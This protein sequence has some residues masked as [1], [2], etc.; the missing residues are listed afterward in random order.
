MGRLYTDAL[1]RKGQ[2]PGPPALDKTKQPAWLTSPSDAAPPVAPWATGQE[3][4]ESDIA[5]RSLLNIM[6]KEEGLSS[7]AKEALQ[8]LTIKKEQDDTRQMHSAVAKLGNA[9]R[10]L[11]ATIGTR[12][13]LHGSWAKF[14]QASVAQWQEY[15][16]TFAKQDAESLAQIQEAQKALA[17]AK[18]CF[19]ESR[20]SLGVPHAI[21]LDEE[22]EDAAKTDQGSRITTEMEGVSETLN[23]LKSKADEIVAEDQQEAKRLKAG[24][25]NAEG[26]QTED[27][28]QVLASGAKIDRPHGRLKSAL[29]HRT[30]RG[31]VGFQP[32]LHLALWDEDCRD[33]ANF[34]IHERVLM[35]WSD[36][37][38]GWKQHQDV[39]FPDF[40]EHTQPNQT[41]VHIQCFGLN[42]KTSIAQQQLHIKQASLQEPLSYGAV[43]IREEATTHDLCVRPLWQEPPSDGAVLIRPRDIAS[44]HFVQHAGSVMRDHDVVSFMQRNN[45]RSSGSRSRTVHPYLE[46]TTSSHRND[47]R[48][49][50]QQDLPDLPA[51]VQQLQ[52]MW[53][54]ATGRQQCATTAPRHF[55]VWFLDTWYRRICPHPAS[56]VL[57]RPPQFWEEALLTP[58]IDEVDTSTHYQ[59]HLASATI[60]QEII[61]DVFAHSIFV[62]HPTP[63]RVAV[64]VVALHRVEGVDSVAM[65]A[66][67]IAPD[68]TVAELCSEVNRIA[69]EQQWAACPI[70]EINRNAVLLTRDPTVDAQVHLTNA[71]VIEFYLFHDAAPNS[72][73]NPS[74][75]I[76]TARHTW[77]LSNVRSRPSHRRNLDVARALHIDT[78]SIVAIHAVVYPLAGVPHDLTAWVVETVGDIP[79]GEEACLL[80]VDVHIYSPAAANVHPTPEVVRKVRRSSTSLDRHGSFRLARVANYCLAHVSE[81]LVFHNGRPWTLQDGSWHDMSHGD[82]VEVHVPPTGRG[83]FVDTCANILHSDPP[84]LSNLTEGDLGNL[85]D[86]VTEPEGQVDD[87]AQEDAASASD[88]DPQVEVSFCI[89]AIVHGVMD[90]CEIPRVITIRGDTSTWHQ[91][92]LRAWHDVV[93]VQA[94]AAYHLVMPQPRVSP[95][96]QDSHCVHVLLEQG[97]STD[98]VP[99]FLTVADPNGVTTVTAGAAVSAP[100]HAGANDIRYIA[101]IRSPRLQTEIHAPFGRIDDAL[102]RI[103][104]GVHLLVAVEERQFEATGED[105]VLMQQQRQRVAVVSTPRSEADSAHQCAQC[106]RFTTWYIHHQRHRLCDASRKMILCGH[107][108]LWKETIAQTWVDRFDATMPFE[109]MLVA[110]QPIVPAGERVD[111][112]IIIQQGFEP[113]S[114]AVLLSQEIDMLQHPRWNAVSVPMPANV[115]HIAQGL[116]WWQ[117]HGKALELFAEHG[118]TAIGDQ[119]ISLAGGAYILLGLKRNRDTD[120]TTMHQIL[121]EVKHCTHSDPIISIA[122]P[123]CRA[124]LRHHAEEPVAGL[125]LPP[126]HDRGEREEWNP[127]SPSDSDSDHGAVGRHSASLGTFSDLVEWWTISEARDLVD[128]TQGPPFLTF[129]LHGQ[130]QVRCDHPRTFRPGRILDPIEWQDLLRRIWAD[131]IEAGVPLHVFP[132]DPQPPPQE[133]EDRAGPLCFRATLQYACTATHR[134]QTWGPREVRHMQPGDGVQVVVAPDT[135]GPSTHITGMLAAPVG[136]TEE[137][138]QQLTEVRRVLSFEHGQEHVP[139]HTWYVHHGGVFR[140]PESRL[141]VLTSDVRDWAPQACALWNEFCDL[142]VPIEVSLVTPQPLHDWSPPSALHVIVHQSPPEG[143]TRKALLVTVSVAWTTN[144]FAISVPELISCALVAEQAE[145]AHLHEG[146]GAPYDLHGLRGQDALPSHVLFAPKHGWHVQLNFEAVERQESTRLQDSL[147]HGVEEEPQ[148]GDWHSFMQTTSQVVDSPG[149]DMPSSHSQGLNTVCSTHAQDQEDF[150]T[151]AEESWLEFFQTIEQSDWEVYDLKT[152][153]IAHLDHPQCLLFRQAHIVRSN[154]HWKQAVLSLWNDKLRPWEP[155][156][157]AMVGPLQGCPGPDGPHIIIWQQPMPERVVTLAVMCDSLFQPRATMIKAISAPAVTSVRELRSV[158]APVQNQQVFFQ[159]LRHRHENLPANRQV[160]LIDGDTWTLVMAHEPHDAMSMLQLKHDCHNETN[161]VAE[162]PSSLQRLPMQS[163]SYHGGCGGLK[164]LVS[165]NLDKDLP[166]TRLEDGLDAGNC[167]DHEIEGHKDEA[168]SSCMPTGDNPTPD[169]SQPSM[170]SIPMQTATTGTVNGVWTASLDLLPF[171][172]QQAQSLASQAAGMQSRPPFDTVTY[173]LHG[174]RQPACRLPRRVQFAGD[175][176]AWVQAVIQTWSD[177]VEHQAAIEAFVVCPQ[178]TGVASTQPDDVHVLIVQRRSEHMRAVLVSVLADPVVH[179][180]ACF[181]P[182]MAI[183]RHVLAAIEYEAHCY[184]DAP[185]FVCTIWFLGFQITDVMQ[186]LIQNGNGI[187]ASLQFRPPQPVHTPDLVSHD[188]HAISDTGGTDFAEEADPTGDTAATTLLQLQAKKVLRLDDAIPSEPVVNSNDCC[189]IPVPGIHDLSHG[190]LNGDVTLDQHLIGAEFASEGL[191]TGWDQRI[192]APASPQIYALSVYTDGSKL[193]NCRTGSNEA[194]WAFVVV[195]HS[196]EQDHILG[197]R[198]GWLGTPWYQSLRHVFLAD[199]EA[200]YD[201][202][203]AEIVAVL[204]AL[205]WIVASPDFHVGTPTTIVA[206]AMAALFAADGDWTMT[207]RKVIEEVVRPLWIAAGI[208]GPIASRWQKAHCNHFYNDVVDHGAKTAARQLIESAPHTRALMEHRQACARTGYCHMAFI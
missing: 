123:C 1:E 68:S 131:K 158:F 43:L 21:E 36:K 165:P 197:I 90:R 192:Q 161:E 29:K 99:V 111:L 145:L 193:W 58:W 28:D 15:T 76:C 160:Y 55:L 102:V 3:P 204:E 92:I 89:W 156:A 141:L 171:N 133:G 98:R 132:V 82:H 159:Y 10:H 40:H 84:A 146:A 81:C 61:H 64:I 115:H 110:P 56:V 93:D 203:S 62:Q 46:D 118:T 75:A 167:P 178:P 51:A 124:G 65:E 188:P 142:S 152:W 194:A 137:A 25:G 39:A 181:I 49:E 106:Y 119:P 72:G 5:L 201:S 45:P 70:Q 114:V 95:V 4:S 195:A 85:S 18:E 190:L 139:V 120:I 83:A 173:F 117:N 147:E 140:C 135:P 112:H 91:D 134:R 6:K 80:I 175:V 47:E 129:F 59:I 54:Q 79:E 163:V 108:R 17:A 31:Q 138:V 16:Q 170:S 166:H 121:A 150:D 44:C 130:T 128:Y 78:D 104:S 88:I 27:C 196:E 208:L 13:Q 86:W 24:N 69:R 37:P 202:L 125:D 136:F 183:R 169:R 174:D 189:S 100:S 32:S 105:M 176:G 126:N 77:I 182:S 113:G 154:P 60:L 53:D 23:S 20:S 184:G 143:S 207:Q 38:W 177:V 116:P 97:I 71:D 9:R 22:E 74:P 187:L 103:P 205:C 35:N 172:L 48:F 153:Y 87:N 41:H 186:A 168:L 11:A 198:Q 34:D 14:L 179:N 144:I 57:D 109:V 155:V 50:V 30:F 151:F 7:E 107:S 52:R 101:G 127:P 42:D 94:P 63:D 19:A 199:S 157:I 162:R 191:Q 206:D 26:V 33:V 200:E 185:T 67:L 96:P 122:P 180:T 12:H 8:S 164:D 149:T 2:I 73:H 148:E 66:I